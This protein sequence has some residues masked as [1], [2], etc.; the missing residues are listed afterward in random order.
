MILCAKMV[1]SNNRRRQAHP[2]FS[3]SLE[4]MS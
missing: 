2:A 3:C 1:L 4:V